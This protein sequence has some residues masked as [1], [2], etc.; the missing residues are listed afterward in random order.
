MCRLE[1]LFVA[2]QE[3]PARVPS[4]MLFLRNDIISTVLSKGAAAT[5][6]SMKGDP[7]GLCWV[8][9]SV[10]RMIGRVIGR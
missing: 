9:H 1:T 7:A 3:Y 8:M 10:G 4:K 6:T 2:L 5:K